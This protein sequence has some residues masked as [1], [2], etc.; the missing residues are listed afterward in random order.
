MSGKLANQLREGTKKSHSLAENVAFV[1]C[2]LKG[3]VER[4]SYR[5]LLGN[6]YFVYL[7]LENQLKS[8]RNHSIVG[9]LYF[10]ELHRQSSLEKDLSY[11]WGPHW[12]Q[13]VKPSTATHHYINRIQEVATSEPSLLV[14][15]SYTRYLGDLSGGQIL[16][17]IAQRGM[18]LPPNQGTHFYDFQDIPNPKAF[19]A[20]YRNALDNL[21]LAAGMTAQVVDEAN[22][23][24]KLNM[25]LFQE[26][27][28]SL[29]KAIGQLLFNN[30]TFNRNKRR[31][32]WPSELDDAA[33]L[34]PQD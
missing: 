16:K 31:S 26:L 23:A 10:P 22:F 21:P 6:F 17:K 7:T 14:A 18:N 15:H 28:G 34:Q 20:Q 19:K 9:Q 33:T 1:Q 11:Y 25:A 24:F 4:N 27:E 3:A 12:S 30:L 8:L 2:F 32:Q 29:I 13:T 5:Q